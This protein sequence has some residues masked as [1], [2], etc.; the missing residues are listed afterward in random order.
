MLFEIVDV[1]YM[2]TKIKG[3]GR[4]PNH[5]R[6]GRYAYRRTRDDT[7]FFITSEIDPYTKERRYSVRKL[8][9]FGIIEDVSVTGEFVTLQTARRQ[10]LNFLQ[11]KP[12]CIM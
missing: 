5:S 6:F 10:L 9:P 11:G 8:A 2:K 1:E 3:N 12:S 7:Y 4:M